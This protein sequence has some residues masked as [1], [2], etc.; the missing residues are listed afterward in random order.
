LQILQVKALTI[1]FGL[2]LRRLLGC[3]L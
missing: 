2:L 1:G 3:Y